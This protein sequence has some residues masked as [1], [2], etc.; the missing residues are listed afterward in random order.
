MRNLSNLSN[1]IAR[2][3]LL[4]IVVVSFATHSLVAQSGVSQPNLSPDRGIPALKTVHELRRAG[5]TRTWS[6]SSNAKGFGRLSSRVESHVIGS[7]LRL[8]SKLDLNYELI[9]QERR[10]Q[11]TSLAT[12]SPTGIYLKDEITLNADG[13][14]GEIVW[15]RE[16]SA[17]QLTSRA[18]DQRVRE[19]YQVSENL[20][21][22]EPHFVDQLEMFLAMRSVHVGDSLI[23]SV[24]QPQGRSVVSVRGDVPYFMWQEIWKGRIDSVFIIRLSE[25]V[26]AQLYFTADRRLVRADFLDEDIRVYQD[27]IIRNQNAATPSVSDALW[28]K[29]SRISLISVGMALIFFFPILIIGYFYAKRGADSLGDLKLAGILGLFAGLLFS[30]A[31]PVLIALL[32]PSLRSSGAVVTGFIS[33]A[34]FALVSLLILLAA[35]WFIQS[36][37]GKGNAAGAHFWGVGLFCG[38]VAGGISALTTLGQGGLRLFSSGTLEQILMTLLMAMIGGV[39]ARWGRSHTSLFGW[40]LFGFATL[41]SWRMV[42]AMML[43]K[44]VNAGAIA[45]LY[46]VSIALWG[47]IL[48]I[49][50]AYPSIPVGKSKRKG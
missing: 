29:F 6:F 36:R 42:P 50:R 16:G 17:L 3:V 28:G 13:N 30:V 43:T 14:E 15:S 31:Q 41:V 8:D 32:V 5:E 34:L 35:I 33:S 44:G 1:L 19:S 10:L 12:F 38:L 25:P 24:F 18:N 37:S 4:L 27:G 9:G 2:F 21:C 46:L 40:F 39:F 22:W 23:D 7:R 48:F 49:I 45:A 26:R 11:T 47:G 20:F